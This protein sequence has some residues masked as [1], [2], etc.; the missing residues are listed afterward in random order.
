MHE[1]VIRAASL[2]DAALIAGLHAASWRST[3]RGQLPDAYLDH[4][5]EAERLLHWRAVLAD[6]RAGDLVLLY[7]EVGFAAV[8]G[9]E[10]GF[11]ALLDNLHVDPALRGGGIGAALLREV[12]R[13]LAAR[14]E[15]A[16]HLWVFDANTRAQGFYRRHGAVEEGRR[17]VE[18][19]GAQVPETRLVFRFGA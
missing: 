2:A 18:F 10:P 15:T 13:R 14:G 1:T 6:P 7:G 16:M 8:R 3:Y 5:V 11:G 17:T 9:R 19:F 4:E 12:A